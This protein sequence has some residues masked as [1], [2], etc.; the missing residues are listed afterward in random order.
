[1]S[2]PPESSSESADRV[3]E[4]QA[5]NAPKRARVEPLE[6]RVFLSAQPSF[7]PVAKY[8]LSATLVSQL[9]LGSIYGSRHQNEGADSAGL[10]AADINGDGFPEI[11]SADNSP[12]VG[13]TYYTAGHPEPGVV[14]PYSG[15]VNF[16]APNT[17]GTFVVDGADPLPT[18]P[19]DGTHRS[20]TRIVEAMTVAD[21]SG[22]GQ[23]ELV[24]IE[25]YENGFPPGASRGA[26]YGSDYYYRS[27][28]Q[29]QVESIGA[30]ANPVFSTSVE[31]AGGAAAAIGY[32]AFSPVGGI[33]NAYTP[34]GGKLHQVTAKYNYTFAYRPTS[35]TA[36]DFNGDGL[37]D[38]AV[39]YYSKNS[40][41]VLYQI[42]GD[43]GDFDG[44]TEGAN[45]IFLGDPTFDTVQVGRAPDALANADFSNDGID[46]LV[47]ANRKDNTI[48]VLMGQTNGE[49]A[50]QEVLPVG[51]QP[52]AIAIGDFNGD[53]NQDIAVV[54]SGSNTVTVFLGQ[55]NGKFSAPETL[56][57]GN[58][59]TSITVGDFTGDGIPDI[60]VSNAGSRTISILLGNGDGTFQPAETISLG[61]ATPDQV[62]S[63]D[64]ND[65]GRVDLAVSVNTATG[66][67]GSPGSYGYG[68][69]VQGRI[70][71]GPSSVY[72]LLNNTT[73]EP[74]ISL[75]N[76]V[77]TGT[78]TEGNDTATVTTGEDATTGGTDLVVSID[79]LTR[80]FPL[81]SVVQVDLQMLAGNDS[82]SVTADVPSVVVQGGAGN[83]TIVTANT[84]SNTLM[85]GA[86]DDSLVASTAVG[87]GDSLLEGMAGNDSLVAGAGND[88]LMGQAGAD[89]LIGGSGDDLLQG[90]AGADTISAGTGNNTIQGG[91]GNNSITGGTG[92]SLIRGGSGNVTIN[93]SAPGF[94]T[95]FFGPGADNILATPN[96]FIASSGGPQDTI[97][98]V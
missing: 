2:L 10:A 98:I 96:D 49:F 3:T 69:Y 26:K 53:G 48:S 75:S 12:Y 81:G 19:L 29:L 13:R 16:L 54:N 74:G 55:G 95:I 24:L 11:I 4:P 34:M 66:A 86:G 83:D 27:S 8:P 68:S 5:A 91:A 14:N 32:A 77:V 94:D 46:D 44:Q 52:S 93:A 21:I 39:G 87:A 72:L 57:V 28:Y 36:G 50:P 76:G 20:N 63:G 18:L 58:D 84:A 38:V 25:R 71:T 47:V 6:P 56:A 90:G 62:V 9:G 17:D 73:S 79:N 22:D 82:V 78:G 33:Y 70:G 61:A 67:L 59:P 31:G 92:N 51:D 15:S 88:T 64:F 1:M 85:G 60:A 43:E 42:P 65:D 41:K 40:I 23:P 45:A 89:S 35:V 37:N 97:S 80:A 30:D 7:A